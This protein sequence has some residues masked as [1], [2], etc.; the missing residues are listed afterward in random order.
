VNLFQ[1]EV[2]G[3]DRLRALAEQVYGERNPTERFFKGEPYKLSKKAGE[4]LL[5]MTLPFA[6]R[7]NVEINKISDELVIRIGSFKR[8]MLLPKQ[9]AAS[10]S[11]R[12]KLEG[13]DLTVYF[14]GGNHGKEKNRG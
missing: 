8:H 1:G 2:L 12:A 14:K 9:V 3:Y 4:Y 13:Q 11:A 5:R 10:K 6:T 7:E